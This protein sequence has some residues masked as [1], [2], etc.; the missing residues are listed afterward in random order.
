METKYA[1]LATYTY[2]HEAVFIQ[3]ALKAKDIPFITQHSKALIHNSFYANP[4]MVKHILVE[5]CHLPK[6]H[7]IITAIKADLH[8]QNRCN[9]IHH[10]KTAASIPP[11]RGEK[12]FCFT[13]YALMFSSL[14]AVIWALV[15]S[16]QCAY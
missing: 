3:S 4:E 1:L 15:S 11:S 7:Q 10:T 14:A 9:L 13:C 2:P 16:L 6:A 5:K 12:G 8:I